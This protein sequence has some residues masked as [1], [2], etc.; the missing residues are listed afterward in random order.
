MIFKLED[1]LGRNIYKLIYFFE[2][3]LSNFLLLRKTFINEKQ[4]ALKFSL[5]SRRQGPLSPSSPLIITRLYKV[6]SS[7]AEQ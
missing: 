7:L 4:A 5:Y 1:D 2:T 6:I 3:R